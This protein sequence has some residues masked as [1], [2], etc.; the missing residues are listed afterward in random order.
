MPTVA[1]DTHVRIQ[2]VQEHPCNIKGTQADAFNFTPTRILQFGN[3]RDPATSL[4]PLF[5]L[6]FIKRTWSW[7]FAWKVY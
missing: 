5:L 7:L 4:G 3:P 1:A 2:G 6:T